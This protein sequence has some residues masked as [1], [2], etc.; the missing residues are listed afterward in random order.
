V[1]GMDSIKLWRVSR[2]FGLETCTWLDITSV[3]KGA[4]SRCASKFLQL[5]YFPKNNSQPETGF[6]V[7]MRSVMACM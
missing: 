3:N 1:H 4:F 7:T 6:L 2:Y 5:I